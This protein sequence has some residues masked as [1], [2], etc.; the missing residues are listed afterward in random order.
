MQSQ[1]WYR[2]AVWKSLMLHIALD[3][4]QTAAAITQ[5]LN[6]TQKWWLHLL[7]LHEQNTIQLFLNT[8]AKEDCVMFSPLPLLA[9]QTEGA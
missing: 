3:E 8:F 1:V 5:A 7:A 4:Q 6:T 2:E 9:L